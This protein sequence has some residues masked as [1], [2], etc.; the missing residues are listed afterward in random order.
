M[1]IHFRKNKKDD[2]SITTS[3]IKHCRPCAIHTTD[4]DY[5]VIDVERIITSCKKNNLD[6]DLF[7][8]TCISHELIHSILERDIAIDTSHE[9][10]NMF[11]KFVKTKS[12]FHIL[13]TGL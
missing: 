11:D 12:P 8:S 9:F 3:T 13:G 5:A 6:F 1:E 7:L 2:Y 4:G 10:D